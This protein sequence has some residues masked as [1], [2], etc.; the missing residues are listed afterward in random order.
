M[1]AG[2][3]LEVNLGCSIQ[4]PSKSSKFSVVWLKDLLF[5]IAFVDVLLFCGSTLFFENMIGPDLRYYVCVLVSRT[6]LSITENTLMLRISKKH[7]T[8]VDWLMGFKT[9]KYSVLTSLF[10]S[11]SH[12]W[13]IRTMGDIVVSFFGL[14]IVLPSMWNIPELEVI[15]ES[16]AWALSEKKTTFSCFFSLFFFWRSVC[17][18]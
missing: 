18:R 12:L 16:T 11:T 6:C 15:F 3:I 5:G 10:G 2:K 17:N 8:L 1:P 13:K 14:F 9:F 4:C 7:A